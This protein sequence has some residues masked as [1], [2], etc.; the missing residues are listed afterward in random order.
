MDNENIFNEA[1]SAIATSLK[2]ALNQL[3]S[4]KQL[5]ETINSKISFGSDEVLNI[6]GRDKQFT[7][8]VMGNEYISET[9]HV[10]VCVPINDKDWKGRNIYPYKS[11]AAIK[12]VTDNDYTVHTVEFSS[13]MDR[14]VLKPSIRSIFC[15]WLNSDNDGTFNNTESNSVRCIKSYVINNPDCMSNKDYMK[16]IK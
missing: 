5:N 10:H 9:P 15:K 14:K 11:V 16:V 8:I 7:Y 2:V 6:L 3:V 13:I 12:L 1:L 4:I